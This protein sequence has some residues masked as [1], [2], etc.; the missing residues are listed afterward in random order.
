[1]AH[2]SRETCRSSRR[3][4]V[5]RK[6]RKRMTLLRRIARICRLLPNSHV[7]VSGSMADYEEKYP[8]SSFPRQSQNAKN[9][10]MPFWSFFISLSSIS[11]NPRRSPETLPPQTKSSSQLVGCLDRGRRRRNS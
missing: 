8:F 1:M 11:N 6:Q 7:L 5:V 9:H 4:F 3:T 10:E 2:T